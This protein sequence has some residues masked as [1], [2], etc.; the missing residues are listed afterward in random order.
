MMAKGLEP[1]MTEYESIVLPIKLYH[2]SIPI[3]TIIK[4]QLREEGDSNPCIF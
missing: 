4:I 2:H 3:V 1:L